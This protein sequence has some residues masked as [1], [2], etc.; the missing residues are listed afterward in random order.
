MLIYKI[1]N[2]LN[3][4]VYIGLTTTSL[5]E[6]FRDHK[7]RARTGADSLLCRA[8]RKYG[9]DVFTA[10]VLTTVE[11]REDLVKAEQRFI[12]EYGAMDRS[13]GYNMTAGG[14]GTWGR[15]Y[16]EETRAKMSAA[17]KRQMLDEEMRARLSAATK[18]QMAD[19][20]M[21]ARLA[22]LRRGKGLSQETRDK[23]SAAMKARPYDPERC[24]KIADALRGK[25]RPPEVGQK[26]SA[27]KLGKPMS[28]AA[29]A[30]MSAAGKGKPKSEAHKAAMRS[31]WVK[32]KAKQLCAE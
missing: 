10:E 18:L 32:R 26:V 31:A 4:K 5:A 27:A 17:A 28:D 14:E 1:T 2:T 20:A 11:T 13:Q 22:E 12:A 8:M 21:R 29:K 16:S 6:R 24:A 19:E 9:V 25:K 3:G 15:A 7:S 23:I 30:A